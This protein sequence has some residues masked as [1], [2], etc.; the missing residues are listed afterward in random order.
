MGRCGRL[1][2]TVC[3]PRVISLA[4]TQYVFRRHP[5]RHPGRHRGLLVQG[6][7]RCLHRGRRIRLGGW[8]RRDGLRRRR[9]RRRMSN[10][11]GRALRT[12]RLHGPIP[13]SGGPMKRASL[14]C[15]SGR[16]RQVT[17][18]SLSNLRVPGTAGNRLLGWRPRRPCGCSHRHRRSHRA[19]V[20]RDRRLCRLRRL[21]AT[22]GLA[23][24][25]LPHDGVVGLLQYL[26]DPRW[27]RRIGRQD[28][29]Q[30]G[31]SLGDPLEVPR[32]GEPAEGRCRVVVASRR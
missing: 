7:S 11:G 22:T 14:R 27:D 28:R 19:D 29:V 26:A 16:P 17:A 1:P 20:A 32:R 31:T 13:L 4:V 8:W 21:S 2:R 5:A 10:L 24:Q 23:R 25:H 9:G 30:V 3:L 15:C 12:L 6:L 18:I